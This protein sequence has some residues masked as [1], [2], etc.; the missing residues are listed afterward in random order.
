MTTRTFP[1]LSRQAAPEGPVRQVAAWVGLSALLFGI[2]SVPYLYAT[3]STPADKVYTGL[4]F[5]VPDHAQY[6]SWVTASRDGLF[7]SNTMTPEPN[8]PNFMNPVMWLLARVQAAFGLSFPA[9]LQAWRAGA[10]LLLVGAVL[11]FF[12]ALVPDRARR[13]TALWVALVA[14]GF[15][16][17]LVALKFVLRLPEAPFPLDV[18]VVEPNTFFGLL[19]YPHLVLAQALLLLALL[20]VWLAHREKGWRGRLLA[21]TAALGLALS[22]PYDLATVYAVVATFGVVLLVHTRRIPWSLVATGAVVV[23]CSAP[24]AFYYQGLTAHDPLWRS[25]LAQYVNAGVWTPPHVHLVV[26]MGLPL[27]LAI[28]GLVPPSSRDDSNRPR[29]R[30]SAETWFVIAWAGVGLALIYAP[31]VYQIKYLGGWQFPLAILAAGAWHDHVMP[32]LGRLGDRLPRVGLSSATVSVALL[33]LLVVPTNLYLFAWR[34]VELR[35]HATP[36]YLHRDEKAA[37]DWLARHATGDD[38]VLAPEAVGQFVPNYGRTRAYLA[39]W[40]MT[41]RY[42]ERVENVRRFFDPATPDDWRAR[43]LAGE[44][45][46]MVLRAGAIPSLPRTWAPVGA[47]FVEPVVVLPQ[48]QLY[49]VRRPG[50]HHSVSGGAR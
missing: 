35:R 39:H 16:W 3:V 23:A 29:R 22:H 20:G 34:I 9:L 49:R 47:D 14:S 48:A 8:P 40:A 10:T 12:G 38:V 28:A 31:V 33:V 32:R 45:V 6:W 24:L 42:H 36:Y 5:D 26:L 50:V 1:A 13:R 27:I 46:T 44:G 30:A 21:G 43:L 4:M 11:A 19:A 15:G 25:V 17:A 37:L 2:T 7:I 41:N 18:Y